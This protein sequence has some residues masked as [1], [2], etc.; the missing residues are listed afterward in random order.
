[1]HNLTWDVKINIKRKWGEGNS[2]GVSYYFVSTKEK[3]IAF[4]N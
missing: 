3:C 2:Q 1:M 4:G